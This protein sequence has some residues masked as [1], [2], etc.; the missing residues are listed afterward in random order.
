[1]KV[2]RILKYE[3][4]PHISLAYES[5]LSMRN[6]KIVCEF[7]IDKYHAHRHFD[8]KHTSKFRKST[9]LFRQTRLFK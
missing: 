3:F 2:V 1:M 5:S 8:I 6:E 4:R 9:L 7:T